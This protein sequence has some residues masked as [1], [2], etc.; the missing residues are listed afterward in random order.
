M[1]HKILHLTNTDVITDS[2]ILKEVSILSE[3]GNYSVHGVGITEN[4]GPSKILK[5]NNAELRVLNTV[6]HNFTLLPRSARYVLVL[7]ELTV[8]F[9]LVGLFMRPK[10]IHCHDTMVI[11]AGVIIKLLTGA[12]LIY[13]AHELESN[14]N[15][16]SRV[17][18]KA[19]FFLE[20]ICWNKID[21]LITVSPSI[22]D[23]YKHNLGDKPSTL[24]LNSPTMRKDNI[25]K[26]DAASKENYFHEKYKIPSD[27]LIFLYVGIFGDGR[28]IDLIVDVF[29]NS[30]LKSHLVFLGY[31][32]LSD[33]LKK[34]STKYMNIHVHDAVAHD[35][36]VEIAKSADVGL[37]LIQN[38][39]LSDYYCLPNKLFEYCFAGIPVLASNFPDISKIVNQY[40]L[41]ICV[42]LNVDGITDGIKRF[43]SKELDMNLRPSDLSALSWEAQALK[44]TKLYENILSS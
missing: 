42:D 8:R 10:I 40:K 26:N 9:S 3:T 30:N 31:G 35:Q 22:I 2:R 13:D 21:H 33:D 39:S 20:K 6:S 7:L 14:K 5:K 4:H 17:L 34:L 37:C 36:V 28:G 1:R 15:G 43:E 24:I 44:L 29:E 11:L 32:K 38:V 23:W 18:S 19:T 27:K 41:G 25:A 16:Q 12:K